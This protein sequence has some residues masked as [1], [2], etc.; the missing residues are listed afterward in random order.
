MG[1]LSSRLVRGAKRRAKKF[2]IPFNLTEKDVEIPSVCPALGILLNP[3]F[4]GKAQHDA[5]PTLD[6]IEPEKGYVSGN[7]KVI[8]AKANAIRNSATEDELELVLGYVRRL[9]GI[10]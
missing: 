7:V 10:K 6:R 2:G 1:R 5:S 4:G 9:K 3:N 8:S